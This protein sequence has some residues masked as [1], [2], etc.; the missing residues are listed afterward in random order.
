MERVSDSDA[1]LAKR[2][3]RARAVRLTAEGVERLESL[4]AAKWQSTY[5]E[6]R[7]TRPLKAEI[8]GVSVRTADRLLNGDPVDRS[9]IVLAFKR[10]DSEVAPEH[11]FSVDAEKDEEL[12]ET[13]TGDLSRL[14]GPT[15]GEVE[16]GL[17]ALGQQKPPQG[18]RRTLYWAM[19]ALPILTLIAFG[20][21]N[22]AQTGSAVYAHQLKEEIQQ[23]L[24]AAHA[25]FQD[26]DYKEAERLFTEVVEKNKLS[27]DIAYSADAKRGLAEIALFRADYSKAVELI[28]QSILLRKE[29]D[30][31]LPLAVLNSLKGDALAGLGDLKE[32]ERCYRVA[33]G[34]Y[35]RNAEP[36]GVALTQCALGELFVDQERFEEAEEEILACLKYL[37]Q[38]DRRREIAA[39]QLALAKL[40]DRQ[41]RVKEAISI[42]NDALTYF[43]SVEHP[44]WLAK[45]NLV[46]G[47]ALRHANLKADAKSS[48]QQSL[49]LYQKVNDPRGQRLASA[50]LAGL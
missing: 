48:F 29:F 38:N 26:A 45:S 34:I 50:A 44:R 16:A 20:A 7:L 4:L 42:A 39:T 32:A 27:R 6:E 49:A 9:S 12:L 47:Q 14:E 3:K 25:S 31:D 46:L 15:S 22:S 8:L 11:V 24:L 19:L 17:V 37:R 30:Q 1:S 33:I 10:L 35:G 2:A 21:V 40:R 43:K 5:S 23:T 13:E 36:M 28:D 18:N 41:G